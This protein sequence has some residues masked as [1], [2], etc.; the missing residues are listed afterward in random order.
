[1]D[2]LVPP[3]HLDHV[4]LG[5]ADRAAG[6]GDRDGSLQKKPPAG[7][8]QSRSVQGEPRAPIPLSVPELRRLLW[9]LVLA[10]QHTAEHI[11]AWSQWR[12]WHQTAAQV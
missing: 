8:E 7:A 9:R 2:R 11:L 1:V 6:R 10:L 5:T 4:G 12:R 3:Y